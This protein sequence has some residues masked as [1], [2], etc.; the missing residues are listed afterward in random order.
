MKQITTKLVVRQS[1]IHGVGCFTR[2]FIKKGQDVLDFFEADYKFVP[3]TKVTDWEL[4]AWYCYPDLERGGYYC[5]SDFSRIS[6]GWYL[7]HSPKPN[8]RTFQDER[9]TALRDIG[10]GEELT[11]NYKDLTP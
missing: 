1:K 8:L 5:P 9:I 4:T 10:A 2:V 6:A 11:I 7:N 3:I